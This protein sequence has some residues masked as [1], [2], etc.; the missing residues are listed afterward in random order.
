MKAVA[1][2]AANTL[3]VTVSA[4]DSE[5]SHDFPRTQCQIT[6]ASPATASA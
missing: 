6:T 2:L 5:S 4:N 1:A 3:S